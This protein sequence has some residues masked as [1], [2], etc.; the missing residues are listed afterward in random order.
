MEQP[1][2]EYSAPRRSPP[3]PPRAKAP[4]NAEEDEH[5]RRAENGTDRAA[6]LL[7][8]LA[9]PLLVLALVVNRLALGIAGRRRRDKHHGSRPHSPWE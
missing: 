6:D 5:G 8:T 2:P 3:H 1:I 9:L 4:G 7:A